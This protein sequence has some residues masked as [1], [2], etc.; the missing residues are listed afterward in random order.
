MPRLLHQ[1]LPN[2]FFNFIDYNFSRLAEQYKCTVTTSPMRMLDVFDAW[3]RDA[4]GWLDEM[5][6]HQGTVGLDHFKHAGILAFWL[7]RRLVVERV[8]FV[9]NPSPPFEAGYVSPL[10]EH[11][12]EFSNE[13][14]SFFLGFHFCLRY[15]FTPTGWDLS[16]TNLDDNYVATI[17]TLLKRKNVS[18]HAMYLIYKSLFTELRPRTD[19][20]G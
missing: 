4:K 7:R 18:P 12:A 6:R 15:E 9:E 19:K 10:Q 13:L 20:I 16:A 14:L 2:F 17:A 11:F 5:N 8:T 3:R 1:E